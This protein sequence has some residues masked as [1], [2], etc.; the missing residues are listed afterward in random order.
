MGCAGAEPGNIGGR[1]DT[2]DTGVLNTGGPRSAARDDS[3][4]LLSAR[5]MLATVDD[6]RIPEYSHAAD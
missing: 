4:R 1:G 6:L 2:P 3:H 5:S